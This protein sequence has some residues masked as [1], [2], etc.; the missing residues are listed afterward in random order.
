LPGRDTV[1][2]AAAELAAR[3][4]GFAPELVLCIRT[5]GSE[6]GRAIGD[7]LGAPVVELD[8][9]YPWS[10]TFAR[11]PAPLRAAL[12]PFKEIA[13]RISTPRRGNAAALDALPRGGRALLVDDTASSGR[14]VRAALA[15]LEPRGFPRSSLYVAVV[16]CGE[17]AKPLVDAYVTDAPFW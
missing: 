3:A 6:L 13:Y 11:A 10:R 14:T 17:R 7:A 15:L 12:W 5:G 2:A 1:Q 9:R 4:R 8:L 16:R